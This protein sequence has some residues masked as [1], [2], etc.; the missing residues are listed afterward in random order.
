[1]EAAYR[2]SERRACHLVEA[3]RSSCRYQGHPREDAALRGR[4]QALAA[5]RRRFGYRRLGALLRRE[6]WT[7]NRKRVY[8]LYREEGLQVRQRKRKRTAGVERVPL[9]MVHGPNERWS[10]DFMADSLA[11]GRRFRTLNVLDEYSRECLRIEVDTSLG[12]PRVVRVLQQLHQSRGLPGAIVSDNGPE[13]TSQAVDQWAYDEKVELRFILPGKPQ[14]NAFVESFNGKF[15]EECLNEHW[16]VSLEEAREQIEAW[17]QDYNR[18]RPHSALGYQT[19]EAF[20]ATR[21]AS[22]PTPVVLLPKTLT[23]SPELTL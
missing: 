20:A 1:M 9:A 7:V 21:L 4:L 23:A 10:M 14:Q 19:P 11:S 17:R 2:R 13:F 22:P 15:R 5:R 18:Q 16:F 3:S 8:R 12:G 6:G